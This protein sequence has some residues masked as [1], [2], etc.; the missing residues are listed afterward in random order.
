[1]LT[2]HDLAC[3][4]G[5]RL[6]F[7]GVH[8]TLERGAWLHV[9]GANGIGKTSL[10]RLLCGLSPPATGEIRWDGEPIQ[11]L[12]ETWRRQLLY[13]GHDSGL[14]GMLSARENLRVAA[15]LAGSRPSDTELTA[16]L[17]RL[18][19]AGRAHLPARFLS[20]GQKRRVALARLVDS[21]APVWVLDE[22]FVAIDGEALQV[23]SGLIAAHLERGGLAV[24]TSHQAVDIPGRSGQLLELTR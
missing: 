1:M 10:L 20:Q 6:L 8:C 19:L 7:K 17:A 11:A 5:E 12:G 3:A 14:Q 21:T 18:G 15:A 24:L 9:T 13:I 4:K 22:P 16:A 23:L 2:L